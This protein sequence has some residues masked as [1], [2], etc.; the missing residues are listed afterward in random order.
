MDQM[1]RVSVFLMAVLIGCGITACNSND[2]GVSE[3]MA[4]ILAYDIGDSTSD[5]VLVFH[6]W[7]GISGTPAVVGE[8]DDE[9]IVEVS[10]A[11]P[12]EIMEDVA[13]RTEASLTLDEPLGD[14]Q[15]RNTDG[16][17]IERR[18]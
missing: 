15:V 13:V 10:I 1:K 8:S 18:E 11:R 3:S 6:S 12:T 16:D 14:R 7:R 4:D 5:L 17:L 2:D 9:V